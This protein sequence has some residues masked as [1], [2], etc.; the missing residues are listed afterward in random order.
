MKFRENYKTRSKKIKNCSTKEVEIINKY[1]AKKYVFSPIKQVRS[2][3]LNKVFIVNSCA[4]C[5][6]VIDR[7]GEH[8]TFSKKIVTKSIF[9]RH[10]GLNTE[11][12]YT[13]NTLIDTECVYRLNDS[14]KINYNEHFDF[15]KWVKR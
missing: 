6:F 14:I 13:T 7:D 10:Q 9:I 5:G 4:E 2:E 3:I 8:S 15:G 12:I 1:F 11:K